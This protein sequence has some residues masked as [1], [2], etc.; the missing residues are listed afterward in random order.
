MEKKEIKILLGFA[1]KS[2]NKNMIKKLK[3]IND[4]KDKI[5][6]LKY[7]IKTGLDLKYYDLNQKIMRMEDKNQDVFFAKTKSSLLG[8][9]LKLFAATFAQ[10]D[11]EN[12]LG[13]F[14]DVEREV[15]NV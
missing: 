8:L 12:I 6:A 15:K 2:A 9:K 5:D 10:E 7:A 13:L 14:K 11:F 4:E 1:K 3:A